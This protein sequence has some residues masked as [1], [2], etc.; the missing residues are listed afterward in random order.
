MQIGE[1]EEIWEVLPIEM[2]AVAPVEPTPVEPV[3]VTVP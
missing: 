3:P 2:P 1:I